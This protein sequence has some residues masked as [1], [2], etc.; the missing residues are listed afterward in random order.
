MS[1]RP[2]EIAS[3]LKKQI[4]NFDDNNSEVNVGTVIS[5]SD[6]IAQIFGL[7]SCVSSELIEFSNGVRGLA[8]NLEEETIGAI[9][10][11]EFSEIKEGDEVRTTGEVASVPVGEE[12]I[13]RVHDVR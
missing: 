11:G 10:L 4:E 12:F 6:G 3:I 1:V 7:K 9:I 13:G 8:L 2:D 5:A